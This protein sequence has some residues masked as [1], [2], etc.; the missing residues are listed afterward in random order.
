MILIGKEPRKISSKGK[1]RAAQFFMRE[2]PP[3]FAI[4][5]LRAFLQKVVPTCIPL[6]ERCG[7]FL[8]RCACERQSDRAQFSACRQLRTFRELLRDGLQLMELTELHRNGRI[9]LLEQCTYSFSTIDDER[10]KPKSGGSEYIDASTVVLD[11]LVADFSPVEIATIGTANKDTVRAPEE[12]CVHE[13]IDRIFL[14]DDFT[15]RSSVRIEVLAKRFGIFAVPHS[16]IF[17]GLSVFRVIF[18]GSIYPCL[19]LLV[20]AHELP[21]ACRATK[22]L[23]A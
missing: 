6:V 14:C 18:I 1:V 2:P 8:S 16:E 9:S 5:T 7:D 12:R 10:L 4:R 3:S 22:P 19:L 13:Q 15:G 21:T 11:F 17:I 20:A 23:T